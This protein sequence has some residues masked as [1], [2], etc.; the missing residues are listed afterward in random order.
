MSN[1]TIPGFGAFTYWPD[2][3]EWST[4]LMRLIGYTWGRGSD[5][6][7]VYAVARHL[8]PGDDAAWEAGFSAL[9]SRT[10][11]A[12]RESLAGG[13]EYS[14]R[15]ALLRA[16]IYYRISGQL[17]ALKGG[18]VPGVDESRACFRDA[19]KLGDR[20]VVP[21]EV[22][23]EET[24]LPGYLASPRGDGGPGPSV[25]VS[26]GIDAFS[27]E[28][29]L[30]IAEPLTDRGYTVLL[31]DLPGAGEARRRGIYARHDSEVPVGSAIDFLTRREDVDPDRVAL[32]GSSLG[33]YYA[34]RV[35]ACE[36]RLAAT[37]IWGASEGLPPAKLRP[38]GRS[39]GRLGQ[40]RALFGASSDAEALDEAATL[41]VTGLAARVERPILFLHGESD[42]LVPV[43]AA[44]RQYDD[45]R[46]PD[47]RLITYPP[48]EPG[49]THCQLDA[50]SVAH[51][52]I[53]DWLDD[54]IGPTSGPATP[55][56]T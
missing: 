56:A 42:V 9:A 15:E 7:E 37:V 1:G 14:A 6:S 8:T 16:T 29:Y 28:M 33:G 40:V 12:G 23:Y 11:K 50:L 31:I 20:P 43:E 47:K 38:G 22:P 4:Q 41:D 55:I 48:G 51:R 5:F 13:H 27:E 49:C 34:L 30:K 39:H 54:R 36:P 24:T 21:V 46:H 18:N 35:A 2:N 17:G 44:R 45:V 3:L 25:I 32:I 26:G 52:D 19:I 53:C 10:E